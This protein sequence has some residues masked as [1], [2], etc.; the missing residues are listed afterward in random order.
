MR[1]KLTINTNDFGRAL[2]TLNM[3][4]SQG[5]MVPCLS[6]WFSSSHL[7]SCNY[8]LQIEKGALWSLFYRILIPFMVVLPSQL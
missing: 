1:S 8:T 4:V 3:S 5:E 7:F 2:T 6:P